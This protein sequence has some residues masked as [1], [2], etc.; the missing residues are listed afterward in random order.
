[1][2]SHNK[3]KHVTREK[4]TTADSKIESNLKQQRYAI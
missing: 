1:M 2:H 3:S 4:E